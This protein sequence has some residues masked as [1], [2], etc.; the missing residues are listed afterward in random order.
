LR[1]MGKKTSP[2]TKTHHLRELKKKR[3]SYDSGLGWGKKGIGGR[4][5]EGKKKTKGP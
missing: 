5:L 3:G 1:K 4:G 2:L